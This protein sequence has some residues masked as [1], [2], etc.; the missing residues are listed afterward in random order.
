[1][2]FPTLCRT[3]IL[4]R[5]L[6]PS[7][8][9]RPFL[10]EASGPD[11]TDLFEHSLGTIYLLKREEIL[12]KQRCD[13][14]WEM[15]G[16]GGVGVYSQVQFKHPCL[17]QIPQESSRDLRKA[18][19]ARCKRTVRLLVVMCKFPATDCSDSP[20]K[21]IRRMMSAYSGLRVNTRRS[22]QAQIVGCSSS[23]EGT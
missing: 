7:T 3:H 23:S 5:T 21:S 1:M 4:L 18:W 6:R 16:E 2:A 8:W 19:R 17:L 10:R 12:E 14:E 15:W 11:R 13:K 9:L 22:R 20:D